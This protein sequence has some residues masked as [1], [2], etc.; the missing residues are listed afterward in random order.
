MKSKQTIAMS[1]LAVS[2]LVTGSL[3]SSAQAQEVATDFRLSESVSVSEFERDIQSESTE[4]TYLEIKVKVPGDSEVFTI[5]TLG[6]HLS[7]D[8][9]IS[10]SL[11]TIRDQMLSA[12][13]SHSLKAK[14]E[15][16]KFNKLAREISAK[17]FEISSAEGK[18]KKTLKKT[19]RIP[20]KKEREARVEVP[21]LT[22]T[23]L[24]TATATAECGIWRPNFHE[25]KAAS[26]SFQG[27]RYNQLKFAFT[28]G[29]L[30]ALAC[31]GSTGFEPD[32]VTDN[33]DSFHYFGAST[34]SFSSS[35]P[36]SYLDTNLFDSPQERV[37]TVGTYKS[38]SLQPWTQ[39]NTYI[40]TNLGNADSD[41]GK[42]V[43]QRSTMNDLC[44]LVLGAALCSF[45]DES[46]I[47][48]AWKF[49]L[50]GTL[51]RP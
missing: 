31:T 51:Q 16:A 45:A 2:A 19:V 15:A 43:W 42:V 28:Q 20:G 11:I 34:V 39:Y 1:L 41:R 27:Q 26:S 17:K 10:E 9:A 23:N 49:P 33:Y 13:A 5:G 47:E 35:M 18:S 7:L 46:K 40:R 8:K 22:T 25:N 3:V 37:Y 50:P 4:I 21:S 36:F 48:Y 44:F 38:S 14:S 30:A 29:Q 24:A 32:L 12:E 6:S